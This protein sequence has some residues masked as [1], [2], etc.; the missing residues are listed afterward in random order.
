MF[1]RIACRRY[2][3]IRTSK[4]GDQASHRAPFDPSVV[5]LCVLP[6]HNRHP[7]LLPPGFLP[8]DT[9]PSFPQGTFR[10]EMLYEPEAFPFRPFPEGNASL[11]LF[12]FEGDVSGRVQ[13]ERNPTQATP[14]PWR[15]PGAAP[16]GAS[17]GRPGGVQREPGTSSWLDP[18]PKLPG[19]A[20]PRWCS[21]LGTRTSEKGS[22][23]TK[24]EGGWRRLER[25]S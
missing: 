24:R 8:R 7:L 11:F 21:R 16:R 9:G 25:T 5:V 15:W 13:S 1:C 22:T 17:Q 10:V 12:L 2:R 18:P 23:R 6:Q 14:L 4:R 19:H 20:T 3:C